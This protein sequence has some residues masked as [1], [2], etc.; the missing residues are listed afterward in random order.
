MD[1]DSYKTCTIVC[2]MSFEKSKGTEILK[3]EIEGKPE[4][5]DQVVRLLSLNFSLRINFHGGVGYAR[6]TM[7]KTL[8]L[9]DMN[10]IHFRVFAIEKIKNNG[11]TLDGAIIHLTLK[12]RTLTSSRSCIRLLKVDSDYESDDDSE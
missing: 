2:I 12:P 6:F 1:K 8:A 10:I 7:K 4:I 5:V 3:L 11:I 9:I